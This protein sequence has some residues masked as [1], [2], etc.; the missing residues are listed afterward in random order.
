MLEIISEEHKSG[1][2]R[3]DNVRFLFFDKIAHLCDSRMLFLGIHVYSSDNFHTIN[4]REI[5]AMGNIIF[6]CS[7]IK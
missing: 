6:L 5:I 2:A 4:G 1:S 7:S 3:K